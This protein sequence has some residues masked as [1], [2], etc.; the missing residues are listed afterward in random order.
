[1]KNLGKRRI[2]LL[3]L[4]Q[5]G[6]YFE[7]HNIGYGLYILFYPLRMRKSGRPQILGPY[8]TYLPYDSPLRIYEFFNNLKFGTLYKEFMT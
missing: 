7:V 1:M 2:P 6:Q 4:E 8:S 3:E 5:P